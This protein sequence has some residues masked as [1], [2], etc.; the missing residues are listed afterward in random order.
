[1]VLVDTSVWVDHLRH[2]HSGLT[3]LLNEGVVACHPLVIGELACGGLKN[4]AE[5]LSLLQTLP[6]S[7]VAEHEE[8]LGFVD[9]HGLMNRGVG[10]ID[11][12]LLAS[13]LLTGV[14]FWTFDKKLDEVSKEFEVDFRN[15]KSR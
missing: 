14:S 2:G 7:V 10:Y 5:I 4:R 6:G 11:V 15:E 8:V 1:M 13:A 3:A 9:D 12:C